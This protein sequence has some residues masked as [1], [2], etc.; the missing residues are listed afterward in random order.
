M[1]ILVAAFLLISCSVQ[2]Q[3]Y[4]KVPLELYYESLCP[5]CQDFIT[6]TLSQIFAKQD[7]VD[8]IDFKLVPYV[9][10]MQ[11]LFMIIQLL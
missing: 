8:I 3:V 9:S 4:P 7:L 1:F 10:E 11:F 2:A 6:T 5:G